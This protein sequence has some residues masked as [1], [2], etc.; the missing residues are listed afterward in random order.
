[1]HFTPVVSCS[2]QHG[3]PT[4]CDSSAPVVVMDGDDV[5]ML[6]PLRWP[7]ADHFTSNGV[8]LIES[9]TVIWLRVGESVS[10]ELV[11]DLFDVVL[12]KEITEVR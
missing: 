1:M 2:A 7:S 5:I 10:A 3:L 9:S 4:A 11:S 8:F 6:P 12:V